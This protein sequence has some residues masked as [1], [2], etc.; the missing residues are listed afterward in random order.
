MYGHLH[1]VLFILSDSKL[2]THTPTNEP[3]AQPAGDQSKSSSKDPV[4]DDAGMDWENGTLPPEDQHREGQA[5]A[6]DA[7]D[8][9]M[10]TLSFLRFGLWCRIL[11]PRYG[12]RHLKFLFKMIKFTGSNGQ[13]CLVVHR[14]PLFNSKE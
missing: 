3:Q 7:Y 1:Y 9:G 6:R 11:L 10:Y 14:P 8:Q 13:Q 2:P 5:D 12:T 4:Q